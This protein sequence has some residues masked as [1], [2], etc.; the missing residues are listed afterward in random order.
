MKRVFWIL[1]TPLAI[2]LTLWAL[3]GTYLA[4]RLEAWTLAKIQSYSEENLPIKIQAQRLTL[5]FLSP[6]I[7]L[8]NIEIRGKGSLQDSLP[9]IK[10]AGIRAYIDLFHL[11]S[12]RLTL[13]AVV[14]ESP[15]AEINIDPFLKKDSPPQELPLDE[16]FAIVEKIPLN[17]ILLQNVQA[18]IH[19]KKMKLDVFVN[20]GDLLLAS[21][22]NNLTA[23][24]NL[25]D[26]RVK[27]SRVGEFGGSLDS[28]L[29][30]T[31]QSLRIIQLGLRLGESEI[32]ARG[33][34]NPFAKVT[35]RPAGVLDLTGKVDLSDIHSEMKRLRPDLKIPAIGGKLVTEINFT[36]DGLDNLK[37]HGEVSTHS[38]VMDKLELGDARIQGEYSDG[39]ISLSEINVHHPSGEATLIQTELELEGNSR[40]KSH[41][42]VKNLDLYKLF[43]SLDLANIPV[44]L[45]L[46]GQLP[47]EGQLRPFF[48]LTCSNVTLKG[49]NLWVKTE[50]KPQVPDLVNIDSMSAQ[51]QV[52]VTTQKVTYAAAVNLGA[53]SGSSDGVIDFET[54]FKINYKTN[55]L[56]LSHVRNLANLKLEG[57]TS[58]AGST[59]GD[60]ASAIFDM[61]LNA[62]DFVFENYAL[63]NLITDLKYRK[64]HLLFENIAGAVNKTQYLGELDVDLGS[65]S[66]IGDFTAPTADLADIALAFDRIYRFPLPVQGVGSIRAHVDGPLDFW[67]LNYKLE[68]VF[69]APIIGPETF[70]QLT[71][72]A[73]ATNGNIKADQV[74]LQRGLS[75]LSMQGGISSDRIMNLYADGKNWRLEESNL[76]GKINSNILG[77]LNFAVEFKE[78]VMTPQVLLKGA[79][80]D[81]L[82][83]DQEI[84]NSN[85]VLRINRDALSG[86]M[87]LFGSRV[88]GEFQIPMKK[89]RT[90]LMVKMTTNNW[91][92]A[93]LLGLIGGANLANEYSSALTS[94]VD[95]RSE[96]GDILKATGKIHI[97]EFSLKRGP[98]SFTNNGPID[99]TADHGVGTIKNFTLQGLGTNIQLRGQGFTAERLGL[100]V[101]GNADLRLMQIFTP[102]LEDMGGPVKISATVSGPLR[103]PEILGNANATNTFVK[104]KGFPHP[105]ERMSADVVFSQSRIMINSIK[106]QMAGGSLTGEGSVV[107]NGIQDFPTSIRI[108]LDGV[109]MNVPDKVRSSGNA[110]L[111]LSG[112][113]FPFTLSGTYQIN[114]ALVEKEFTEE[115]EGVMGVRQSQY[116][117][118]FLREGQFE[119]ILLDLQILLGRNIIIKNSLID[120]SV[121]GQLQVKGRPEAPILLG[122]IS[123]EKRSK[124]IFKDRVFEIQSGIIDFNDPDEVN[125]NLYISAISRINEYDITLLAQGP[126]KSL[127]IHLTSVPPLSEQDIISV[128]ALGVTSSAM[129]QNL[130]SRQQ[131]EQL[132]VEIGGAVL[133]KPI[134]KQLESTLGLNL[135]LTSQYDSTRNISVPKITLSRRLS[136]KMKVSGSRPVGDAQSYDIKLEYILNNN[137]TAIGSFESRGSAEESTNLQSTQQETQSIFGL[138]L[139]FKREFK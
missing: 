69:K 68:S 29:N 96:L 17:R 50:M 84:P 40:F 18:H 64:G 44:G 88:Q 42:Q 16:I 24:T 104:I 108:H 106:G 34:L 63:G 118:K 124:I 13:S 129:D 47:C 81:T 72:N 15:E 30:L 123:T 55:K 121:S 52:Q 97:E 31:R 54:G 2:F 41:I 113:W 78:G 49:Q 76:I 120:G 32:V 36:V 137:I 93:T 103:K 114:S 56:D 73:S 126:S 102:F 127:T 19:S 115:S 23:K 71:F 131:A 65:S 94:S 95:L 110:N 51:G 3:G 28:H 83:E 77:S 136:E 35:L 132:G 39:S 6:S 101:T 46:E 100:G 21:M 82:F 25:P 59:S 87:S 74:L 62:R 105:L 116:L 89:G 86:Q 10:I 5:K 53:S 119:P 122:K 70:N 20:S 9:L 125:P 57:T 11:L 80:T 37:A 117:P 22:G 98:L 128:I 27:L 66:L 133:A 48:Q 112:R 61:K 135:S 12:G 130:Q 107:I 33:E 1:L 99:I 45:D 26:L 7:A 8:E 75:T 109:T 85:A 134:N 79:V 90:P 4:P 43:Q 111:L 14:A 139:E 67:K 58:I 38:V 138:D 92:Y 60:S 91:N